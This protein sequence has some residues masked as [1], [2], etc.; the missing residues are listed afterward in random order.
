[1]KPIELWVSVQN[2]CLIAEYRCS[3]ETHRL[4]T[5]DKSASMRGTE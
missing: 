5:Q 2:F 4:V 3:I 1:M